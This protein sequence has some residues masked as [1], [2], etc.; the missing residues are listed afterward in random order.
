MSGYIWIVDWYEKHADGSGKAFNK[1]IKAATIEGAC[2]IAAMEADSMKQPGS[3]TMVVNVG[4]AADQ[5]IGE[6]EVTEE[7]M[8]EYDW[9]KAR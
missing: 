5:D 9:P 8:I 6:S 7:S 2:I 1:R 4:L 3:E